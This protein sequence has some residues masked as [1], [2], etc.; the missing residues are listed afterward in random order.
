MTLWWQPATCEDEEPVMCNIMQDQVHLIELEGL[1]SHWPL[2]SANGNPADKQQHANAAKL[3]CGHVFHPTA[4]ALHFLNM[5]MRCPVCREGSHKKLNLQSLPASVQPT[6]CS[7]KQQLQ[8]ENA[9]DEIDIASIIAGLE[10]QIQIRGPA[11]TANTTHTTADTAS[12]SNYVR[13]VLNTSVSSYL[14]CVVSC[15]KAF[16]I[17]KNQT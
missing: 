6:F 4:L 17:N 9:L 3:A 12:T 13:S 2:E 14:A 11:P 16:W 7:K 8:K 10:L 5:A 1:P 15:P